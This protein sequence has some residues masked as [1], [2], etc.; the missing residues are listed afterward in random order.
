MHLFPFQ[1]EMIANLKKMIHFKKGTY[2]DLNLL[3]FSTRN[4]FCY[5]AYCSYFWYFWIF[6]DIVM[7]L[8]IWSDEST[9]SHISQFLCCILLTDLKNNEEKNCNN[10]HPVLRT[11]ER[12]REMRRRGQYIKSFGAEL[13]DRTWKATMELL[14]HWHFHPNRESL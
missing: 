9:D 10:C 5:F 6:L 2:A 14:K 4:L 7:R 1:I 3:S 13:P 8:Q 11:Q 12:W